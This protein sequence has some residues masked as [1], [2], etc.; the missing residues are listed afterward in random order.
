M[1]R[2]YLSLIS[3]VLWIHGPL[4]AQ[5]A[6][7][8]VPES[9]E[10]W[11]QVVTPGE[12]LGDGLMVELTAK[13]AVRQRVQL[14][15][16][17][18]SFRSV[19]AGSYQ[20][21]VLDGGGKLLFKRGK[22]LT[23]TN[24]HVILVAPFKTSEGHP[25]SNTISFLELSRQTPR[26]AK[27][28]F[29]AAEKAMEA[30]ETEKSVRYLEKALTIDPQLTEA[31]VNLAAE[32]LRLGR[33]Q[34][35]LQHFQAAFD[36]RPNLSEAAYDFAMLLLL[37]KHHSQAELV[38]REGLRTQ[39]NLPGLRG[40]L[41]ASLIWQQRNLEEAYHH[42]RLAATEFP[43]A[44]LLAA[45][46]LSSKRR[47]AAAAAQIRQYLQGAAHPC[48]RGDLENWLARMSAPQAAPVE[49]QN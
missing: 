11:G 2:P 9:C 13:Q 39:E 28:A 22:S 16:G 7:G 26:Q 21:R 33:D 48:E 29:R 12:P 8:N 45:N 4:Q 1:R 20:F 31:H 38:A 37:T 47:L 15:N 14:Q 44:R 32:Y 23:G 5:P 40:I 46:A 42:L 6:S 43:M 41:A 24:D 35:A 30:G 10:V 25:M 18:F 17:N 27:D 3:I 34:D 49:G 36:L 19:P